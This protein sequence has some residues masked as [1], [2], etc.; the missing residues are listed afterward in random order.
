M[1]YTQ[2]A[3]G[4]NSN[5]NVQYRLNI[6]EILAGEPDCSSRVIMI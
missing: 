4:T 6:Q 1:I 3:N 2:N 5:A